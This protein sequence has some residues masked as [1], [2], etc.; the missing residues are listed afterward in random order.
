MKIPIRQNENTKLNDTNGHIEAIVSLK[1][2][3]I[4]NTQAYLP[5]GAL[6]MVPQYDCAHFAATKTT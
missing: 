5:N 2:L 3:Y 1:L 4:L 6:A